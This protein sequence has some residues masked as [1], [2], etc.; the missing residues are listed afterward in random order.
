[1]KNMSRAFKFI[2][3]FIFLI[4]LTVPAGATGEHIIRGQQVQFFSPVRVEANETVNGDV[5]SF[6][7]S[8]H[9]EGE[10]NGDV[11][12]I[13]SSVDVQEAHVQGGCCHNT[14]DCVHP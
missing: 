6:F 9:I 14:A 7:G 11:I 12:G 2:M 3:I 13:L 8:A 4:L 1:M 5:V 10:I